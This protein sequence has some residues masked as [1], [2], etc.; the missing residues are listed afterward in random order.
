MSAVAAQSALHRTLQ[1]WQATVGKK[2]VMAI[3][4]CVLFGFVLVHMLGNLQVYLGRDQ[5]NHYAELLKANAAVLWGARAFLLLNVVAHMTAAFQLWSL[6]NKARPTAYAVT[7]ST[8]STFASRTMYLTGPGLLFFL[9]F[10][11]AHFTTGQA[12]PAFDATDV[13][14]NVIVGFRQPVAFVAYILAMGFLG[15]HLVHGVWSMFQSA[16]LNHPKY[17]PKIRLFATLATALIVGGNI[18]IPV[19]AITRLIGADIP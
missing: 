4:G 14:S 7:R 13:Y 9:I 19:A 17:M 3:T 2:Y 16:G 15:F 18:S 12:H 5:I 11:L 10:H 1:F 6:K 8:T